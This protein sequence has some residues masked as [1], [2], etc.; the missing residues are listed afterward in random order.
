[1]GYIKNLN[2]GYNK[3]NVLALELPIGSDQA[4]FETLKEELKKNSNITDVS[5]ASS[6]P[7]CI[8][9]TFATKGYKIEGKEIPFNTM[10]C[11]ENYKNTLG[12]EMKEGRFFNPSEINTP[13]NKIIINE[14]AQKIFGVK[15]ALINGMGLFGKRVEIVGVIKDFHNNSLY[16]PIQ[17]LII[18]P[19][20]IFQSVIAV[21]LSS[22]HL[23]SA[24]QVVKSEWQKIYPDIPFTYK[25]IDDEFD[26]TYKADQQFGS[27]IEFFTIIAAFLAV[28][29][30]AGLTSFTTSRRVKEIGIRKV[31]GASTK[32]ILFLL[33]KEVSVLSLI[34]CFISAP[35]AS[36]FMQ[37]W[38][39]NFAYKTSFTVWV[40]VTSFLIT[41]LIAITAV[42]VQAI[43]A[44]ITNPIKSLRNE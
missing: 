31:L 10:Y 30:L 15:N 37:G 14:A 43:K 35:V 19:D 2:L 13:A 41:M 1:M 9:S 18:Y 27:L 7:P 3:D 22:S 32:E 38:L 42:G 17:P 44:A 6:V 29:G 11:D 8:G 34:A 16:E 36:Y 21:K 20:K 26:K 4:K 40:F 12:M 28:I 25:F 33:T 23:S 39:A 5:I 24:V